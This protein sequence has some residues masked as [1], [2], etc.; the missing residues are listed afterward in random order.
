MKYDC[1]ALAC[2][3]CTGFLPLM[4]NAQSLNIQPEKPGRHQA[5]TIEYKHAPVFRPLKSLSLVLYKKHME[6]PDTLPMAGSGQNWK[7]RF[8]IQDSS[9]SLLLFYLTGMDSSGDS[10]CL[11]DQD[12]PYTL[13]LYSITGVPL[14]GAYTALALAQ[15]GYGNLMPEDP[16]KAGA[17]VEKELALYPDNFQARLLKY[18]LLLKEKGLTNEA[19]FLIREDMKKTLRAHNESVESLRF[20][21]QACQMIE[22]DIEI[23]KIQ[24][25]LIRKNPE[26]LQAAARTFNEIMALDNTEEQAVA[27]Q[28]F[29]RDYPES[30]LA[31]IALSQLASAMIELEDST[32]MIGVGDRLLLQAETVAGAS[33]LSALAGVLTEKKWQLNRAQ[34]YIDRALEIIDRID[35]LEHPPEISDQEWQERI[36]Y[37]RARYLDIAGWLQ[38]Q[39]NNPQSALALLR[40]ASD[41]SMEPGILFHLAE[42]LNQTG[43]REQAATVYARVIAYGGELA[44]LSR[45]K[46]NT[47]W[48]TADTDSAKLKILLNQE[49]NRVQN[50]YTDKILNRRKIRKAPD[51]S[52]KRI[53]GGSTRLSEV[54][55]E[56]ILLCFW[57]SWSDASTQIMD[58]L[59]DIFYQRE[60]IQIL[61]VSV[62][63]DGSDVSRYIR[64][65]RVPFQV[66]LVDRATEQAY[67]LRGVPVLFVIDS[68][69]QIHFEHKGYRPDLLQILDTE[70]DH[71]E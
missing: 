9:V 60:D 16:E 57:A 12:Q 68:N 38:V 42:A 29:I 40:E 17:S 62:D 63:R 50:E 67:R 52:L 23:Q 37:T 10:F 22:D 43:D 39:R 35:P 53:T 25:K 2:F 59:Q 44:N 24:E 45:E 3:L 51:F 48:Q 46:L 64:D 31:E 8:S 7:T 5:I 15:S 61:A 58:M 28:A 32:A 36:R 20:A 18:T 13:F 30:R 11:R 49:E 21:L 33:G 6:P 14:E 65:S 4:I 56:K 34:Q 1:R 47:I 54:T 26:G 66:L 41:T 70:L 69:G 19:V 55:G 71:M 27:L